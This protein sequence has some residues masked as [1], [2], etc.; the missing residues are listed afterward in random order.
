[1]LDNNG[2][3][4]A[5]PHE[6]RMIARPEHADLNLDVGDPDDY[7][8][9]FRV[10]SAVLQQNDTFFYTYFD[11]AKGWLSEDRK[12]MTLDE[13]VEPE[14]MYFLLLCLHHRNRDLPTILTR[15][16]AYKLAQLSMQFRCLEVLQP[17]LGPRMCAQDT[18]HWYERLS[19]TCTHNSEVDIGWITACAHF[20]WK[21]EFLRAAELAVCALTSDEDGD[22]L[23]DFGDDIDHFL[24]STWL[25]KIFTEFARIREKAQLRIYTLTYDL[26]TCGCARKSGF[27]AAEVEL[28]DEHAYRS[29]R[30]TMDDQLSFN[31]RGLWRRNAQSIEQIRTKS[32][33]ISVNN[34][35]AKVMEFK[36]MNLSNMPVPCFT[37]EVS[38]R[39]KK[40]GIDESDLE[41]DLEQVV[42]GIVRRGLRE[43]FGSME[44]HP[45]PR[46]PPREVL[47]S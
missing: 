21:D 11:P 41:E 19:D 36:R 6:V 34:L 4:L 16:Q 45:E 29:W 23:D 40:C 7:V 14:I 26:Q 43:A 44:S 25:E 2:Q 32:H 24:N 22:I 35:I 18:E 15:A 8:I 27:Q 37:E 17:H 46:M 5:P 33:C 10:S 12:T 13:D 1:M 39:H 47:W 28:C 20:G 30:N 3:R 31:W 9:R 38:K 42:E